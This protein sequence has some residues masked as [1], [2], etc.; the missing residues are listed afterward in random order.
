MPIKIQFVLRLL[1]GYIP[2][3]PFVKYSISLLSARG[4][5]PDRT[6]VE[7]VRLCVKHVRPQNPIFP[8]VFT[9]G[10]LQQLT[11]PALLLI[12]DQEVICNPKSAVDRAAKLMPDLEAVIIPDASHCLFA[13][14]ADTVNAY[15]LKFLARG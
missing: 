7:Q 2:L 1:V 13:E 8:T 12:G 10:E 9:D 11:N 15:I 4:Y 6:V 5:V 14:Q 3:E